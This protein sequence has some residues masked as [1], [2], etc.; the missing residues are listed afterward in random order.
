MSSIG[1]LSCRV[2]ILDGEYY[3]QW[4]YKMLEL[5][6]E[7]HLSKYVKNPYVPPIDPLHPTHEEE[8]DMLCNLRAV[9]L[10]VRAL[11]RNVLNQMKN[12]EC[13]YNLWNDLEKRYPS[14]SLSNLDEIL[15]KTIVFHK[16]MPSDPKFDDY[17]FELRDLMRA[18]GDVI[19]INNIIVEAIHIHNLEH[20]HDHNPN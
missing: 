6:N 5:F 20:C 14:Y 7:F 13:A 8:I 18:K 4:K 19:T 15:H 17:L 2:P 3:S 1:S 11:P 10:I 9:N 16:M 12:F